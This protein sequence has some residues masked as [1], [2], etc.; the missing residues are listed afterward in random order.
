[1]NI[2]KDTLVRDLFE[3]HPKTMSFFIRN[4]MW[5]IGCPMQNCHT[6][7]DVSKNYRMD[8]KTLIR[9]LNKLK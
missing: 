7:E 3:A 9:Q 2:N 8:L 4:R 1:M 6:L 5:C